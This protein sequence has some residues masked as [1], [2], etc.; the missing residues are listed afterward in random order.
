M[1]T[2]E[3]QQVAREC[4]MRSGLLSSSKNFDNTKGSSILESCDISNHSAN[5][6]DSDVE[7]T[8]PSVSQSTKHKSIDVP[9]ESLERV[10]KRFR[11]YFYISEIH[12]K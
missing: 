5:Y 2:E 7:V 8:S 12:L 9:L 3:G 4:L 1:L 10:I 11:C 6:L